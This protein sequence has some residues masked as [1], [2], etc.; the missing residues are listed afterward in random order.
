MPSVG[1]EVEQL[2]FYL[3]LVGMQYRTAT[4]ENKLAV[5]SQVRYTHTIWLSNSTSK[6][7]SKRNKNVFIQRFVLKLRAALFISIIVQKLERRQMLINCQRDKLT[8]VYSYNEIFFSNKQECIYLHQSIDTLERLMLS[9]R[10][11]T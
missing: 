9:A 7:L 10:S 1:T 4:W 2:A 6:C 8:T 11:Q 3:L 5:L